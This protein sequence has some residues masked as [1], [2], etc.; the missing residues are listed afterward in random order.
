MSFGETGT[1]GPRRRHNVTMA[2]EDPTRITWSPTAVGESVANPSLLRPHGEPNMQTHHKVLI[3]AAALIAASAGAAVA[4][5]SGPES[6][7]NCTFSN[8]TTTCAT[9]GAPQTT[10]SVSAPDANGCTITTTTTTVTTTY[11]AHR[12]TYN[13]H[14]V[15]LPNPASTSSSTSQDA[16]PS[17]PSSGGTPSAAQAYCES[18]GYTYNGP[19]TMTVN[20]RPQDVH[21]T[22]GEGNALTLTQAWAI[23]NNWNCETELNAWGTVLNPDMS[24]VGVSGA[25]L[26][27]T[28]WFAT[29]YGSLNAPA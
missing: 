13:S 10:S 29:C 8:G 14:G 9:V 1:Y 27:T 2:D 3:G 7:S 15:A 28:G 11:A 26:P 16:A 19:S 5:P 23:T 20:G 22:C 6:P 4:A 12:G 17:C 24:W 25:T 21:Y 18:L